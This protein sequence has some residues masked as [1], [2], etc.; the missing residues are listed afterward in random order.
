MPGRSMH[1]V[2]GPDALSTLLLASLVEG[3]ART[4]ML[5]REYSPSWGE[6]DRVGDGCRIHMHRS[7][8][9]RGSAASRP[10]IEA[11]GASSPLSCGTGSAQPRAKRRIAARA[12][13]PHG[14]R[15]I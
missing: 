6:V 11:R 5:K 13:S 9:S 3:C 14:S 4:L 10:R 12:R 2:T 1:R 15:A 7:T 8:H